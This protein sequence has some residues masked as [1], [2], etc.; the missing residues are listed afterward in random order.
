MGKA[1][2]VQAQ[3]GKERAGVVQAKGEVGVELVLAIGGGGKL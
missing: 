2:I 3:E 1:E